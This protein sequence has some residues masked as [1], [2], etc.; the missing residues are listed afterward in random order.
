VIGRGRAICEIRGMKLSGW[1]AFATYLGVHLFYLGSEGK[2][3]KLLTDWA[4]TWFG[5]R[6]NEVIQGELSSVE[7]A[8]PTVEAVR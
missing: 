7:R 6:G 3:V 1:P 5:M 4:T 2:R 8:A